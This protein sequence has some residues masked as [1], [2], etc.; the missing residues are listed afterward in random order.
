MR[1]MLVISDLGYGGAERQVVALGNGL[2]ATALKRSSL[3][4]P[5]TRHSPINCTMQLVCL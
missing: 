5:P 2:E 3:L 4:S 1:V